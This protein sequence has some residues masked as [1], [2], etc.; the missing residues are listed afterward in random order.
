MGS[1]RTTTSRSVPVLGLKLLRPYALIKSSYNDLIR[2]R[3]ACRLSN[4]HGN[5][6]TSRRNA[7]AARLHSPP[8]DGPHQST[9]G[10]AGGRQVLPILSCLQ[11]DWICC[12]HREVRLL[13]SSRRF[14]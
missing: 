10:A 9:R 11:G 8:P 14:A 1:T 13:T 3:C 2:T 4:C 12:P 6:P 5:L 7:R